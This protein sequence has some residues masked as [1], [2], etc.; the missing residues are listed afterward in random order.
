MKKNEEIRKKKE[1][2]KKK[3]KKTKNST[4]KDESRSDI[5]EKEE[6]KLDDIQIVELKEENKEKE[7]EGE[8]NLKKEEESKEHKFEEE[9]KEEKE[10]EEKKEEKEEEEK[11]EKEE[12]EKK[13]KEIKKDEIKKD[14]IKKDEIKKDEIKKDEIKK[15]EIK[16]DENKKDENKKDEN[17]KDEI[18]KD[19]NKKDE[20][21]KDEN[22]EEKKEIDN[23]EIDN[24]KEVESNKIIEKKEENVSN[25]PKCLILCGK[26]ILENPI[27]KAEFNT[28]LSERFL[29][30]GALKISVQKTLIIIFENYIKNSKV[31]EEDLLKLKNNLPSLNFSSPK[32]YIQTITENIKKNP[33]FV[34][35]FFEYFG[36]DLWLKSVNFPD[37]V[38]PTIVPLK[39]LTHLIKF[40]EIEQCKETKSILTFPPTNIRF[41]NNL[42]T[43]DSLVQN[44]INYTEDEIISAS[45]HNLFKHHL[46][47]LRFAWSILKVFNSNLAET[48]DFVNME[49]FDFSFDQIWLSLSNYL[50][51][52]RDLWM[53]PIKIEL[54]QKV[55]QKTAVNRDQVPKI[56]LERLK[57]DKDIFKSIG[58]DGVTYKNKDD[59]AF[60]KSFEQLKEISTNLLRPMKPSGA[61]P[62]IS[63]EV[64]FK[65]E[66]VMGEGGPYRQFFADISSELQPKNINSKNYLNLLWPSP[67]NVSKIGEGRDKFVINPSA[68]SA[69]Q[70]QLFEYLGLL[71]GC[72]VRTG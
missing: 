19:E 64:I 6:K 24:K 42:T 58:S 14:V 4:E 43:L 53:M 56:Q 47:D 67:N 21:K 10:E 16:K 72:C 39:V 44:P 26:Q 31:P 27:A 8:N 71:M 50:S 7:E 5:I 51:A 15:D 62:F 12:E 54:T 65:G 40:I 18:K 38:K 68:R 70:L 52:Y 63:F 37:F 32:N 29:K 48:I 3:R 36:Y 23:K 20:N 46:N 33:I 22:N 60:T 9:K 28:F 1:D 25:T 41:T 35:K 55:M 49:T 17:K 59:F 30:N 45:Y 66:S 34:W 13:E 69:F 11:K 61:D 57:L 2:K